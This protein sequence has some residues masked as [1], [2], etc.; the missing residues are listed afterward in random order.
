M[1]TRRGDANRQKECNVVEGD[2]R[3]AG[4]D[5]FPETESSAGPIE[6]TQR[7]MDALV[8]ISAIPDEPPRN[9]GSIRAFSNLSFRLVDSVSR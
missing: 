2:V 9:G 3:L 4:L 1:M 7:H 8:C 6:Q 5:D